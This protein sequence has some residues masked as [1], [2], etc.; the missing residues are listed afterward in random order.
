MGGD[1][2]LAEP[3]LV[4]PRSIPYDLE[5]RLRLEGEGNVGLTGAS[6]NEYHKAASPMM[7][8]QMQAHAS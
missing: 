4:L 5:T 3:N 6:F 7:Q 1:D 2:E 8:M